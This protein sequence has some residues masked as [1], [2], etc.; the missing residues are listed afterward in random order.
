MARERWKTVRARPDLT[1]HVAGFLVDGLDQ[2]NPLHAALIAAIAHRARSAL[3]TLTAPDL[4]LSA[5]FNR[6]TLARARL[7]L[8]LEAEGGPGDAPT[9]E[10]LSARPPEDAAQ[11]A[12][13]HLAGQVWA[14]LPAPLPI[15]P[16][17]EGALLA[18]GVNLLE[19]PDPAA[20]TA[21]VLRRVKALLL[22]AAGVGPACRPD[23]I[24]IAVRDWPLYGPHLH[25]LG[26]RYGLPIACAH[27]PPL[28]E[29]P[30]V[31]ALLRLL[32]L[33]DSGY[34]QLDVIDALR[35]PYL[36]VP[37]FPADG[38]LA[39]EEAARR[40]FVVSGREEWLTALEALA[41]GGP[42]AAG[43]D[44]ADERLAV[45]KALS[46]AAR[47]AHGALAGLFDA[48]ELADCAETADFVARIDG[49]IGAEAAEPGELPEAA[50][51]FTLGLLNCVASDPDRARR[52]RDRHAVAMLKRELKSLRASASLLAQ[53]G[54]LPDE[55]VTRGMFLAV[56]RRALTGETLDDPTG[57]DGR[58]LATTVNDARGLPHRHV[59]VLG[60]S[61]GIFPAPVP[62]DPLLLDSERRALQD[63][64][65]TLPLRAERSDDEGLFYELAGLASATLTLSRP[66]LRSGAPWVASA[67][68]RTA[69]AAFEM[70]PTTTFAVG[71]VVPAGEVAHPDEAAL[72][73]AAAARES[74]RHWKARWRAGWPPSIPPVGRA[75]AAR[76]PSRR[77]GWL[78]ASPT[79][80]SLAG[81]PMK[82]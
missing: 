54:V 68:W 59:F 77:P 60:L 72:A 45:R 28:A 20:E 34:R 37:G 26:A 1:A 80:P 3:I 44:E 40:F 18:P 13:S 81:W 10:Y 75:C 62:E 52:D 39:L 49:W 23:D 48:L 11:G 27:G 14:P 12:I 63:G 43:E 55:P 74:A 65:L 70:P 79:T 5:T 38:I 56:L 66:T 61:E 82:P 64:G 7:L 78:A 71:A 76:T 33:P 58:V 15:P 31:A 21:A 50:G 17:A 47:Q 16:R 4:D 46:D 51:G 6:F 8:A 30:A 25:R 53:M 19:A 41:E 73:V 24:L 69:S 35:T 32:A 36:A 29:N 2:F 9:V 42:G 22:G 67:L 57:R